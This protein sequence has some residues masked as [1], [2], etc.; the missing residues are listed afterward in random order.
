MLFNLNCSNKFALPLVCALALIP[1]VPV[2][3]Q[4]TDPCNNIAGTW[5]GI[6]K[7]DN[8]VWDT[9]AAFQ[10]Y[11]STIRIDFHSKPRTSCGSESDAIYTGTCKNAYIT[12]ES[13][14]IG[15]IFGNSINLRDTDG[16]EVN[17]QK[18]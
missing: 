8:C 15:T 11:K 18:Q 13:R 2:H 16:T 1:L 3:A 14:V 12:I 7:S 6:T 9:T 4:E 17:L 10:Q 5:S